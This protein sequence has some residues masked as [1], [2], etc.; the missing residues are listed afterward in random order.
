MADGNGENF[1][2]TTNIRKRSIGV[3]Y[4]DMHRLA[5]VFQADIPH[6]RSRQEARFT[7]NLEAVTDS[8]H[9]TTADGKFAHSLHHG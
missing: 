4:A 2:L 9:Q 7:K 1:S 5:D 6:Q 8:Q 3:F